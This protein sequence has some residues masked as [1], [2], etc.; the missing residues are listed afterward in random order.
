MRLLQ[1]I[2]RCIQQKPGSRKVIISEL[3]K[4]KKY[5]LRHSQKVPFASSTPLNHQNCQKNAIHTDNQ[6]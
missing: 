2:Y 3:K 1:N 5:V 6:T 4:C